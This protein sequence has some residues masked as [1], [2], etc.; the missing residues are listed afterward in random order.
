MFHTFYDMLNESPIGINVLTIMWIAP[1][2]AVIQNGHPV[3][4]CFLHFSDDK[5]S[6]ALHVQGSLDDIKAIVNQQPR[7]VKLG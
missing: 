4:T 1:S 2:K 7:A 6:S 3:D 5:G